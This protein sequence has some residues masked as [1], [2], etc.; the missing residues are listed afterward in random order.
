MISTTPS[1]TIDV[2][3]YLKIMDEVRKRTFK[4]VAPLSEEAITT[5]YNDLMSPLIWDLGHVANFE[6][7]WF[8]QEFMGEE[9][10]NC[11][12]DVIYN[13]LT[14]PRKERHTLPIPNIES[15]KQ[16]M[17]EV[18]NRIREKISEIDFTQN[19]SFIKG[20]F[21]FELVIRH[22]MQHQETMIIA[23]QMMEPGLYSPP[24]KKTVPEGGE[25]K[26]EMLFIPGGEFVMGCTHDAFAYDNE[27]PPH[28]VLVN[29]FYLDKYPVSNGEFLEFME[30]G[31]Y[32]N[33]D[34]W[35]DEGWKWKETEKINAPLYWRQSNGEWFVRKFDNTMLLDY[36]KPVMHVS[37]Y[38]AQAYCKFKGKRLPAESEW[39][40]AASWS[41]GSIGKVLFPWGNYFDNQKANLNQLSF[42]AAEVGAYPEGKSPNGCEQMVGE[43]WEWTASDFKSYP[44]F[45][46]YPYE[47]YS[48]IFF[49]KEYKVLRGGSWAA[50]DRV[51]STTFRN[52][53]YPVRRQIFNGF[54]CAQ[55]AS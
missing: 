6:E 49:G 46:A 21:L 53:D 13:A 38:E 19:N 16:Y 18:R 51:V 10:I 15:T 47:E 8:L 34:F 52:W 44:G 29:P 45:E 27:K 50:M 1:G 30:A 55:D 42:E 33:P 11:D 26:Q 5:Q 14:K 2:K 25:V 36:Q 4:L 41:N 40:F 37:W 9:P 17:S 43:H 39:E 23:L 31:G 24:G 20:S 48:Q 7:I 3:N 22:E 12:M 35:S 28:S 54:R 32:T